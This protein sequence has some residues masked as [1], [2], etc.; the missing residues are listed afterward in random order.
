MLHRAGFELQSPGSGCHANFSCVLDSWFVSLVYPTYASYKALATASSVDDSHWLTYW[1]AQEQAVL[2]TQCVTGLSEK[3]FHPVQTHAFFTVTKQPDRLIGPES[4][5]RVTGGIVYFQGCVQLLFNHGSRRSK[6]L[7][8]V[9]PSCCVARSIS[10]SGTTQDVLT[11]SFLHNYTGC[12][13][14]MKS[15]C[16]LYCGS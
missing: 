13:S 16:C 7:S 2:K 5:Q 4:W 12:L 9:G 10:L 11:Q 3:T 6:L 14:T 15:S 1:C 8:V